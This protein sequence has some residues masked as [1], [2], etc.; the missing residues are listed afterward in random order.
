MGET[1]EVAARVDALV[2]GG[3]PDTI[4]VHLR[5]G[6]RLL[7]AL[8]RHGIIAPNAPITIKAE[9][10]PLRPLTAE[11]CERIARAEAKRERKRAARAAK[12]GE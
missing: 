5:R 6:E 4:V 2:T 1:K 3:S 12:G 7:R 10:E 11:D 9:A 8:R